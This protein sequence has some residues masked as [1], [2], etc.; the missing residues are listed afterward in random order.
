M[1]KSVLDITDRLRDMKQGTTRTDV[2]D[3]DRTFV[4]KL[5]GL[6]IENNILI[7]NYL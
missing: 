6:N 2:R 7:H 3:I 1:E 4:V 5:G